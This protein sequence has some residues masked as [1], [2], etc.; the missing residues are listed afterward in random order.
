MYMEPQS[1]WSWVFWGIPAFQFS[2]VTTLPVVQAN[3][4]SFNVSA[5]INETKW[6][7]V[8]LRSDYNRDLSPDLTFKAQ[9]VRWLVD[10]KSICDAIMQNEFKVNLFYFLH[11]YIA[12]AICDPTQVNEADVF[13]RQIVIFLSKY[14]TE[15]K[16]HFYTKN[17]DTFPILKLWEKQIWPVRFFR[18]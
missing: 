6:G 9:L 3:W 2:Y 16:D 10:F 12:I 7:L 1:Y 5:E 8:S 11:S 4:P 18:I 14:S 17:F 15:I 13:R